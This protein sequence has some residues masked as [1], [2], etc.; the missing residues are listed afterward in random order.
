[1]PEARS[2]KKFGIPKLS[3]AHYV[4]SLPGFET[5]NF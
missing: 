5:E 4:Q 3:D 1:V 2:R